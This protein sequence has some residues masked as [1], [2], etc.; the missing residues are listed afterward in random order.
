MFQQPARRLRN[1][2]Y[3]VLQREVQTD[4]VGIV[5]P[6][7]HLKSARYVMLQ[8]EMQTGTT[9]QTEAVWYAVPMIRI[10]YMRKWFGYQL[11]VERNIIENPPAARWKIRNMLQN[12]TQFKEVLMR[13]ESAISSLGILFLYFPKR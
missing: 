13:A 4:T 10:M 7:R 8:R 2:H 11:T 6:A 1:V 5:Q 12:L 9:T 3:A